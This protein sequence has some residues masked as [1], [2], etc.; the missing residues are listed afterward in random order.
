MKVFLVENSALLRDRLRPLIAGLEGVQL[1]GEAASAEAALDGIVATS[2][3]AVVLDLHLDGSNGFEVL[4]ALNK[5]APGVAV[6]VLTN[7]PSET[8]RRTAERL[9]ARG[10]FD[11]TGEIPRLLA[12]LSEK[13]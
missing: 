5:A 3:D 8:Y 6:Y 10:F 12:A 13:S 2:A 11:K 7:F 9:G 1:V 4:R